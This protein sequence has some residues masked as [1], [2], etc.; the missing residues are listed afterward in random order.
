MGFLT[1]G[2]LINSDT[3]YQENTSPQPI[4]IQ[5]ILCNKGVPIHLMTEQHEK[6]NQ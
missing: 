2:S 5:N 6:I 3:I 4:V 1:M